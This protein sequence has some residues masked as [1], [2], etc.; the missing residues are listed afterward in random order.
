MTSL[1]YL[2]FHVFASSCTAL[3]EDGFHKGWRI[4]NAKYGNLMNGAFVIVTLGRKK[5]MNLEVMQSE[6]LCL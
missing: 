4:G 2:L 5:Q 1:Y 6:V 3:D